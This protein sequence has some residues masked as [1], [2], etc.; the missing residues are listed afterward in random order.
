MVTLPPLPAASTSAASLAR[1]KGGRPTMSAAAAR[2]SPGLSELLRPIPAW[3]A[4]GPP[5]PCERPRPPYTLCGFDFIKRYPGALL[6]LSSSNRGHDQPF[7]AASSQSAGRAIAELQFAGKAGSDL[8][9]S[10]A[11]AV[12]SDAVGR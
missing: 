12:D 8:G 4:K 10:R 3:T 6:R 5:K 9:Q 11:I 7:A 2:N 1:A